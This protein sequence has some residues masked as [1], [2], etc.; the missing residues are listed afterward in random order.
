[1]AKNHHKPAL[2]GISLISFLIVVAAHAA[3]LY[4]IWNYH[5]N[6]STPDTITLY[7]EF[8]SPPEKQEQVS[9]A[10]KA[11]LKAEHTPP[12]IKP[13]PPVRKVQ[14]QP[15]RQLVAKASAVTP[16]EPVAPPIEEHKPEPIP[17][18]EQEQKI[19][20]ET[21]AAAQP[22]QMPAG[23]VKLSSELSVSC[24]NLASPVYPALSRRLG[25]EG[26]LVLQVELDETGRISNA[27]VIES[28]GHSRLDN[29]ALSAVKTWRCRPAMRDG[30]A[31]SAIA[32]QPFN[33]V[34][35]GS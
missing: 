29:A 34:I 16:Q 18:P 11:E 35:E 33:F 3:A 26:K 14:P 7:A 23:P 10:P 9:Q 8:I 6:T 28:S 15:K 19:V 2:T 1:M 21:V 27:K 20:P 13:K 25:E 5:F 24:P 22:S 31:V 12:Q 32:L 17:D 30:Q 4:G